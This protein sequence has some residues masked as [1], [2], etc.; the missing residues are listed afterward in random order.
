MRLRNPIVER[1]GLDQSA[2][3]KVRPR[4]RLITPP[5]VDST[6]ILRRRLDEAQEEIRDLKLQLEQQQA[7]A[8]GSISALRNELSSVKDLLFTLLRKDN[9]RSRTRSLPGSPSP[10]LDMES[11][12]HSQAPIQSSNQNRKQ[13]QP[14]S[15]ALPQPLQQS[16]PQPAKFETESESELKTPQQVDI[17]EAES[18][19][20][21]EIESASELLETPKA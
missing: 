6:T 1:K 17:I 21:I 20:K 18:E 8:D 2:N 16:Q 3:S 19:P 4:P 14:S 7:E 12:L 10:S 13:L 5:P 15:Q 11:W 9:I